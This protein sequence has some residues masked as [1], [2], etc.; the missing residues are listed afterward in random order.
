M[1]VV[2]HVISYM[3]LITSHTAGL[4]ILTTPFLTKESST[5]KSKMEMDILSNAMSNSYATNVRHLRGKNCQVYF[6]TQETQ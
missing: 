3:S 5:S 4:F 1:T 6:R 2:V